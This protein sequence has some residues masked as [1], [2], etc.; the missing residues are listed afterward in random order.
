MF[1]EVILMFGVHP[2]F[3]SF[4]GNFSCPTLMKNEYIDIYSHGHLST[5]PFRLNQT[6]IK[7]GLV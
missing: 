4:Y 2:C 1:N 5:F 3:S 6:T 7:N